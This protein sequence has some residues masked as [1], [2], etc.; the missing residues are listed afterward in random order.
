MI[1]SALVLFLIVVIL[2]VNLGLSS[3][4]LSPSRKSSLS[5]TLELAFNSIN[6]Q[7]AVGYLMGSLFITLALSNLLGSIPGVVNSGMYYFYTSG[8]SVSLWL[9]L[10]VLVFKTQLYSFVSHLLPYG[11]PRAL[12]F[13]LP[14][15][16]VFSVIIRP[17]TLIVRLRTNLSSGHIILFIFSYFAV[18]GKSAPFLSGVIGGLILA[19]YTLEVFV[20]LL[21]AYIFASLL[22]LYYK[23]VV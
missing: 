12:S 15:I 19:L 22:T 17:F 21:Q 18:A 6:L 3:W 7:G 13:I 11:T 14:V 9:S 16:E 8:I 5:S 10:M 2:L 20:C 1:V 4:F 23:E